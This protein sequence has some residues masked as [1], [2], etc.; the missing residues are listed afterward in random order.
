MTLITNEV[1]NMV[2]GVSQQPDSMRLINQCEAQENAVSN[3]V[4][5]LTKRP[6]TEHIKELLDNP[7]DNLFTP[8]TSRFLICLC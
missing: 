2:G 1:P 3:T 7:N 8:T 5:G 4:E 6:P